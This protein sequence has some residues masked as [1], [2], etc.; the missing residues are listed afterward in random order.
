M[1]DDILTLL[2]NLN[3]AM[4]KQG[5]QRI[6]QTGD[7]T[8]LPHLAQIVKNDPDESVRQLARQVG[9]QLKK[10]A[11]PSL[12]IPQK[13]SASTTSVRKDAAIETKAKQ[14]LDKAVSLRIEG[15]KERAKELA[16]EAFQMYPDL[17]HDAHSVELASSVMNAAPQVA[18]EQLLS[19]KV[20]EKKL[21]YKA[22]NYEGGI[23]YPIQRYLLKK[24][25]S[26]RDIL[27]DFVV[28]IVLGAAPTGLI[29]VMINI[30][31]LLNPEVV[32]AAA[33][34]GEILTDIQLAQGL[35][36]VG[37]WLR[38][39]LIGLPVFAVFFLIQMF[40]THIAATFI[41]SGDGEFTTLLH[42]T[43][44]TMTMMAAYLMAFT[45]VDMLLFALNLESWKESGWLNF[46]LTA[47]IF[48]FLFRFSLKVG[49][50]YRFEEATTA[51]GCFAIALPYIITFAI[52]VFIAML[53]SDIEPVGGSY[54]SFRWL[55]YLF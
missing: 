43:L 42:R 37:I 30:A 12:S 5:V 55:R 47:G 14:L 10:A 29:L 44:P 26:R 54:R 13:T 20:R 27:L 35:N 53:T 49:G 38:M 39:M 48:F 46:L 23:F 50:A 52:M 19:E 2:K 34:R 41:M 28:F 18:I 1:T 7:T 45:F 24:D 3:P 25:V 21:R 16:R 15:D 31:A 11:K 8:L 36:G 32:Q 9:Q 4:R 51:K 33:Q 22:P 40:F 17:Q 6:A